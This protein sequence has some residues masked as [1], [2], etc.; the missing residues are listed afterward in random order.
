[1]IGD[2]THNCLVLAPYSSIKLCDSQK[3]ALFISY[4]VYIAILTQYEAVVCK[5]TVI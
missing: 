3:E 4:D 1:M 2:G 5:D